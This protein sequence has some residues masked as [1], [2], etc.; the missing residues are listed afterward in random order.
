MSARLIPA[1][2]PYCAYEANL[3]KRHRDWQP[4]LI[5]KA[6]PIWEF[7]DAHLPSGPAGLP[8]MPPDVVAEALARVHAMYV[9][10]VVIPVAGPYTLE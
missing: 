10:C 7:I 3:V 4:G 2:C 9:P 6:P 8:P 5:A 1:V